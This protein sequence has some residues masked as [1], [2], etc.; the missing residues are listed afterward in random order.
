VSADT[1]DRADQWFADVSLVLA[2][3]AFMWYP[4]TSEQQ[5]EYEEAALRLAG[6]AGLPAEKIA[7]AL[8]RVKSPIITADA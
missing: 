5:V 2:M 1:D 7:V 3:Q 8:E 6:A 4:F